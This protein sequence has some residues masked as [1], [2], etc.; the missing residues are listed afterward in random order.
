MRRGF[1]NDFRDCS[2]LIAFEK[3][4]HSLAPRKKQRKTDRQQGLDLN[5]FWKKTKPFGENVQYYI[6]YYRKSFSNM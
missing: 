6:C 2:A 1:L 4:L 5:P 3:E